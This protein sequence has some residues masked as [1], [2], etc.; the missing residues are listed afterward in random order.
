MVCIA[1]GLYILLE[2][3]KIKNLHKEP[4]IKFVLNKQGH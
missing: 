3:L 4:D 2:W 1:S